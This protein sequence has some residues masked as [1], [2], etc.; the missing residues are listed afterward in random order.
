MDL[1]DGLLV[2]MYLDCIHNQ[3][4]EDVYHV[5]QTSL[6]QIA[7]MA[8]F[9]KASSNYFEETAMGRV[10]NKPVRFSHTRLLD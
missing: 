2:P 6:E 5:T 10:P 3:T 7:Y 8:T 9:V 1:Y 4:E